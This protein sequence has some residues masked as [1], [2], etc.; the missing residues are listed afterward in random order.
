MKVYGEGEWKVRQHGWS[1]RRVWRKL[2]I[3][4]D[5][6]T[7][8]IMLGE[9]TGNDI[10]DCKMLK[11]LLSKLPKEVKLVQ[12]SADGAFDKR[13]CYDALE[14]MSVQRIAIPPQKNAHIWLHGNSGKHPPLPRDE[15]LRR[16]RQIGRSAWKK[17]SGYHRRSIAETAMF[18]IKTIFTDKLRSISFANQCAELMIR[19]KVLNLMSTLGMPEAYVVA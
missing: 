11:P 12:V 18:R 17:E 2:H 14:E 10:A 1:K 13:I 3:G 8:D 15:N 16:I 4:V 9:V 5:E 6:K 19:L 7:G